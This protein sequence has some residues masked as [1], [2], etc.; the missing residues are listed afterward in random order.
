MCERMKKLAI[1]LERK[2]PEEMSLLEK[3]EHNRLKVKYRLKEKTSISFV[4]EL[5]ITKRFIGYSVAVYKA[6][7]KTNW[8]WLEELSRD[9][10]TEK[11]AWLFAKNWAKQLEEQY[12]LRLELRN[13]KN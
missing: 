2:Y 13:V 4:L 10:S 6:S 3:A 5:S 12:K 9:F 8:Y 11:E 1:A 7:E